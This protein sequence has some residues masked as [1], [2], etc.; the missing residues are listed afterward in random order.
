[1]LFMYKSLCFYNK[2]VVYTNKVWGVLD[3]EDVGVGL[4]DEVL[5]PFRHLIVN[6]IVVK[7]LLKDVLLALVGEL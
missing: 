2:V 4:L 6:S 3:G 5:T 1:M 7:R